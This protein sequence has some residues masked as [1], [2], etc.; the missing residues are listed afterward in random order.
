[1]SR[2]E[3][4]TAE[5]Q[6]TQDAKTMLGD[7]RKA[8][9]AMAIPMFVSLMVAQLNTFVDTFWCSSLGETALAAVGIVASFYLII[10]GIGSGI[11][12]GIS[13]SIAAKIARKNK[14]G[15][16]RVAT[17]SLKFML[18]VGLICVPVFLLIGDPILQLVGGDDTYAE[19]S[20]YGF[21]FYI[22]A[23]ILVMQGVCAGI[24]RGE[25]ASRK[26]MYILVIA[27]LLNI[28]F[29]PLFTFVFDWGIAGLSWATVMATA[30][31]LIPFIY[32]YFIKPESVYADVKLRKYPVRRDDLDDFLAVGVP[33]TVELDVMY[34]VNFLLNYFV[35]Y[36]W[37][38]YGFAVYVT[39]YKYVDLILVPS[40]A[41]AGALVPVA[42]AAFSARNYEKL[43]G[44]YAYSMKIAAAVTLVLAVIFFAA[45]DW[46]VILF[47]Y[48]D[49]TIGMRGDM[50]HVARILLVVAVLFAGINIASAL[51]QS[52]GMARASLFSTIIRNMLIIVAFWFGGMVL[53]SPDAIWWGFDLCEVFGVAL[54]AAWAEYGIRLR[55]GE[56]G[57]ANRHHTA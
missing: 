34:S 25:G 14:E 8:I 30:I 20:D 45:M 27:A 57:P 54:M 51:L 11:G 3:L 7:Y 19:G 5:K 40:V 47:T 21:P 35:V 16:D 32:W 52:I 17:V 50:I 56:K 39:A 29:D 28:V 10:V 12:I 42:S 1:M 46:A 15:V 53:V 48:D 9:V 33:K 2:G 41:L 26:S 31:S 44:A 49:S 18:A 24:L 37:G 6:L 43:R 38:S 36:C 22:C 55:T 4:E 23:W 13:S